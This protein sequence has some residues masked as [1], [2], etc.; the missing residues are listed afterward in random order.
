MQTNDITGNNSGLPLTG[1]DIILA[2]NQNL[3][4]DSGAQIGSSGNAGG[5]APSWWTGTAC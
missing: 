3:T 1:S 4:L 2:A 5:S